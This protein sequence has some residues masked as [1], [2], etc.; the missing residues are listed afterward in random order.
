MRCNYYL[1]NTGLDDCLVASVIMIITDCQASRRVVMGYMG[2]SLPSIH[3]YPRKDLFF[4]LSG[5]RQKEDPS[6]IRENISNY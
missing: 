6:I 4:I 1:K 3:R 5:M 2:N